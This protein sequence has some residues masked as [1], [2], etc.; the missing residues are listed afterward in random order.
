LGGADGFLEYASGDYVGVAVDTAGTSYVTGEI[1]WQGTFGSITVTLPSGGQGIFVAKF[2]PN[3]TALWADGM[4]RNSSSY[5]QFG[6]GQSL[7]VDGAGNVYVG[8]YY[9]GTFDFDPG[10]GQHILSSMNGKLGRNRTSVF[11][12]KLTAS[13]S[14]IWADS[15]DS[16]LDANFSAMV[17]DANANVYLTG[18]F[19]GAK[20]DFNP[21]RGT[22]SLDPSKGRGFF[23]KLDTNG[24]F[25][26]A[27]N[28][29]V[30]PASIAVDSSGYVYIGGSFSGTVDFDPGSGTYNLTSAG[31]ND[32]FVLKLTS[33]GAFLSVLDMGGAGDD[34]VSSIAI[35]PLGH[36]YLVGTFQLTATFGSTILTSQG[37][38]NFFLAELN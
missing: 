34:A 30:S 32:A 17:L 31:G 9:A 14:F 23:E 13:G 27:E 24:K 33:A 38:T 3:G 8:G 16:S 37:G 12:E 2:D 21:G 4:G 11:V 22:Y 15:F 20:N 36:V 10:S 1:N 19:G 25:V 35:D 28:I 26:W 6:N 29:N 7:A 5:D 18:T